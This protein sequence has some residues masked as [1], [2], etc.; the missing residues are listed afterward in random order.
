MPQGYCQRLVKEKALKM[1]S[2]LHGTSAG[3]H[4]ARGIPCK[5]LGVGF[6]KVFKG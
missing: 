1:I 5:T 4:I 6:Y 3:M 2:H